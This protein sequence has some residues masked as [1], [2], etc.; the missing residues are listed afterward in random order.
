MKT[1]LLLMGICAG[2]ASFAQT[3]EL[4]DT[5]STGD[6]M[7]YYV[8]DSNATSYSAITGAGAVWDY[9]SVGAYGLPANTNNVIDRTDSDFASFFPLADYAE[10]FENSVNTFFT[11]DAAGNQVIV[12]GFVFQEIGSDFVIA[13]DTDPL[14]S[15]KFPMDLGDT[16]TDPISGTATVPLA[17]EIAIDGEATVTADGTGSLKIAGN[18][19]ENVIRVHTIE[20]SEGVILGSPAIITR[21]SYVYFDIDNFNMPIFIH[22]KVLAELGAGGDFGFT[23]V[24]SKDEVTT[25]VGTEEEVAPKVTFNLFPNPV[26]GNTAVVTSPEGTTSLTILNTVGQAVVTINTPASTEQVDVSKLSNGV[27]FIQAVTN[28]VTKTQK[29]VVK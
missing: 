22:A 21:D 7:M 28:G 1:P 23:A 29:F 12:H 19:Y 6:N 18:T 26:T 9:N 16:Y 10:N 20:V 27:Y 17:G 4:E 2:F 24:Y 3:I 11:N 5:I 25:F 14:I 15:F 8:L 13:Y